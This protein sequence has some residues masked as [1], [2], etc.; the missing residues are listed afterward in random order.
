MLGRRVM[1]K[2]IAVEGLLKAAEE[3]LG[4]LHP[5]MEHMGMEE[6]RDELIQR[7]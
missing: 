3:V 6:E 1:P 2:L 5:S 7:W 4:E